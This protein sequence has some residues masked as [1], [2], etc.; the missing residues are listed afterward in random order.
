MFK[1]AKLLNVHINQS[2]YQDFETYF[3]ALATQMMTKL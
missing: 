3:P 1:K 2:F